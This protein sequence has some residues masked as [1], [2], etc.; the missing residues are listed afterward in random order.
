MVATG[1]VCGVVLLVSPV[2]GQ[3]SVAPVI[4]SSSAFTVDEGSTAVATL[5]A[6]DQDTDVGDLV[7]SKAGGADA[8]AFTLSTSGVLAFE[9]AKDFEEPDD[10]DSVTASMR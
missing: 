9:S 6:T 2:L 8:D 10:D 1:V 7:W 3:T 4:T 5:T